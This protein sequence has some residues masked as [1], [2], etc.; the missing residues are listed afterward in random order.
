MQRSNQS[1]VRPCPICQTAAVQDATNPNRP[2][3]SE[4]CRYVDLSRWL[5]GEDYVVKEPLGMDPEA[6]GGEEED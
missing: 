6:I 4:R 5:S 1:P 2:F 3:C